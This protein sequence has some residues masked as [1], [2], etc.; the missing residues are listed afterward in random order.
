MT[1]PEPAGT[2]PSVRVATTA[3]LAPLH[4]RVIARVVDYVL[5]S[6]IAS[7]VARIWV[8]RVLSPEDYLNNNVLDI[9]GLR[10]AIDSPL[11]W[12]STIAV[13]MVWEIAWLLYEG[14]TPGKQLCGLFV[15]DPDSP[16]G[17][18][19]VWPA[20]RRNVHRLVLIIP[21]GWIGVGMLSL[22]SLVLMVNDPLRRQS[23][24]DRVGGTTVH[25]LKGTNPRFSPWLA[26]FLVSY[27][28]LGL[29]AA[30]VNRSL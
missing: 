10:N 24:M 15:H 2:D 22:A 14:A 19:R 16:I 9:D 8:P 25:R 30:V 28:G 17:T 18:V 20:V 29:I 27:L 23:V 7:A 21:F 26:V 4:L 1:S 13:T 12:A 6:I 11:F 5:A 3:A